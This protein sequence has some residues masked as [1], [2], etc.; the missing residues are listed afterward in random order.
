[1]N[2]EFQNV[3]VL[4]ILESLAHESFLSEQILKNSVWEKTKDS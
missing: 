1:M 3:F 2:K 4:D